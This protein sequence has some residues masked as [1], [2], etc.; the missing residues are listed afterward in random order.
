MKSII[1]LLGLHKYTSQELYCNELPNNPT[2]NA[3]VLSR[4]DRCGEKYITKGS[5][6]TTILVPT[7]YI[8]V[9]K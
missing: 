1:C 7:K 6:P 4:C 9:D 2:F 8:V 5:M 3:A